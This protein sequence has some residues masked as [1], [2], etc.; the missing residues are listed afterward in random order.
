MPGTGNPPGQIGN[1]DNWAAGAPSGLH[2]DPP[3]TPVRLQS[4]SLVRLI[5]SAPS[6]EALADLA[7]S[8]VAS[9]V[10]VAIH[11]KGY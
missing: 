1:A 7:I 11:V 8:V 2:K 6:R 4:S 10:T 9:D 5:N 3:Q